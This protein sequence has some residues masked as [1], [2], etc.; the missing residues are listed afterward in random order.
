MAHKKSDK[1]SGKLISALW[2]NWKSFPKNKQKLN[3][4][5]IGNLRRI[6]GKERNIKLIN[7]KINVAI[8]GCGLIGNKRAN[9]LNKNVLLSAIITKVKLMLF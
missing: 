2:D 3:N 5:D 7:K 4:S 8:I 1:I 6:T 9:N